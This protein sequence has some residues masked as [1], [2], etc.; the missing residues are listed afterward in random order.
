MAAKTWET[1]FRY[2]AICESVKCIGDE[3]VDDLF[4]FAGSFCVPVA[5]KPIV[6][7]TPGRVFLIALVLGFACLGGGAFI[8]G[9]AE[10]NANL[11]LAKNAAML[12]LGVCLA[13]TGIALFFL[14]LMLDR[15]IMKLLLGARGVEL[16]RVPGGILCAEVSDPDRAKIKISVDGDDYV[17]LLADRANRR[18]L[19]EGVAARYMIRAADVVDLRPFA[20]V[21]Y[22]GAEI[23]F[24][25]N[26]NTTLAIAIARVS[27]LLE[28]TRQAPVLSFLRKL[29]RNRIHAACAE[30]LQFGDEFRRPA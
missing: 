10:R 29:I 2:R 9:K 8:G 5:E 25:I 6:G 13:V 28:L 11:G 30:A 4:N 18:L 15:S 24:R 16:A 14:P 3:H 26:D 27:P 19:M 12:P 1:D 20:F 21:N 17:L 7:W 23:A 22:V